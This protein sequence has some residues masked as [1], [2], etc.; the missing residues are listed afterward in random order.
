MKDSRGKI[1][2]W[3]MELSELDYEIRYIKGGDNGVAD[4]LSR[5]EIPITNCS[6]EDDIKLDY[7]YPIDG[8]PNREVIKKHQKK[9]KDLRITFNLL[10][11]D[12]Q[13]TKGSLKN[14]QGL[15]ISEG[16]IMQFSRIVVPESMTK[17][18]IT[19]Y[20]GLTIRLFPV[21]G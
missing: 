10:K 5:V 14:V 4:A 6:E 7:M 21:F 9:D 1:T 15:R 2:R 11:K 8:Y 18:I 19:E 16:L 13:I 20:H 12:K 3:A 17:K